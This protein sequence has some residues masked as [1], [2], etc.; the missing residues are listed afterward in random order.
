[1]ILASGSPQ[2]RA[3][4]EQLG[5]VFTVMVPNV[6]EL[7]LGE[8]EAVV[9]ENARRKAR[10]AAGG[11]NNKQHTGNGEAIL[12]VD[13]IVA[14]DGRIYGKPVDR[15]AAAAT[16]RT[17]GGRS[18][19]V[20]SGVCVIEHGQERTAAALTR[21]VFRPLSERTLAWYLNTGEWRG[22]AGGYAIQG[23]GAAL[24]GSIEGDYLNVVGLPVS[25][26]LDL[27]PSAI[28]PAIS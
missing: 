27:L 7:A 4:L 10:A 5:V 11:P 25:T 19:N 18:H 9:L 8:P 24:V 21:V 23:R 13:T 6:E 12:G 16:L 15:E 28:F 3:I 14:L 26:L 2:R 22:R 20:H 17:L 1:M